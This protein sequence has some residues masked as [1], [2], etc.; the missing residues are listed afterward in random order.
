MKYDVDL[1]SAG[2]TVCDAFCESCGSDMEHYIGD[3]IRVCK[4]CLR[5][6]RLEDE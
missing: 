2:R 3:D 1:D 4:E 5:V 6:T